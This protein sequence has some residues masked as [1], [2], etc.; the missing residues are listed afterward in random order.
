MCSTAFQDTHFPAHLAAQF[1]AQAPFSP[2]ETHVH[3]THRYRLYESGRHLV[4][5]LSAQVTDVPFGDA[6]SMETRFDVTQLEVRS[7]MDS[8]VPT[9]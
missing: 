8:S 9:C 1:A 6:F 2:P 7:S 5:E 4:V 3:E